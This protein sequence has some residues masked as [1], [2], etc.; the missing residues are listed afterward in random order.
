[1]RACGACLPN[2]RCTASIRGGATGN[3]FIS[4]RREDSAAHA[5]RLCDQLN[6]LVGANRVFMD[7]EDIVPGQRFAQTI[8]DT[9]ARCDIA[10]IVI[11]PR[12]AEILHQRA[13]EQR[14]DYVRREVE[15]ALA[16]QITVVPVLVGGASMA[17]L[18]GLPDSL[19]VLSQFEAA[20]LR[21]DS[22]SDDCA[23]LVRSLGL[24]PETPAEVSGG[25]PERK[26]AFRV[27][28][29]T[30]VLMGLVI[31]ALAWMGTGRW[32]EYRAR[33]ATI[34]QL[35]AT[36]RTQADR[37]EYESAFKTYQSLL[38]I[39]PGNRAAMDLEVDAAMRWLENFRV[40]APEGA[41]AEDLAGAR[42]AEIM[43]VLDAGLARTNGQGPRAADILAHMGWAHWLNQKLAEREFG[44]AAERDLRQALAVDSSNVFAHAMLGNLMMQTGGRT[45][46]ALQ[47]LRLAGKSNKERPLVRQMQLGAMSY[48]RDPEI[49]LELIRVANEMRRNGEPIDE[50]QRRRILTEYN[51]H[52]NSAEEL[53]KTLSAVAPGDT[54]ATYLW[55]E[56]E[57][58]SGGD[59]EGQRVRHDFIRASLLEM[60]GKRQE[61]L[62]AF[63]ALRG[64]LKRRGYD[65]RITTHVANAVKRLS[66]P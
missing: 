3:V 25:K 23:R 42:L 50:R 27:L 38:K 41:K 55:L 7:V 11:G 48:P 43:P 30:A 49:R 21:D 58:T 6:R 44:P 33:K 17:E 32:S 64:E 10:L 14:S 54:W 51:P 19:S 63:E 36:G 45:E 13:Q 28:V 15:A 16:R 34:D 20:Q 12:W 60:E 46:E 37:T 24:E 26:K 57:E 62:A 22:F 35:L 66:Q 61:A 56:G 29:W 65:G 2:L 39:D 53:A 8:D 5:G 59:P 47:H 9:M 40:V 4:Y 52:T 1:M 31:A 18:A